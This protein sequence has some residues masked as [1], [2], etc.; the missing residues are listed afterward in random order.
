MQSKE[1]PK[2]QGRSQ[3]VKP[4]CV[5]EPTAYLPSLSTP[6]HLTLYYIFISQFINFGS[7][8]MTLVECIYINNMSRNECSA[9][10]NGFCR[11]SLA[12]ERCQGIRWMD[13]Q[14]C[15]TYTA[16]AEAETCHVHCSCSKIDLTDRGSST[17][18]RLPYPA[19]IQNTHCWPKAQHCG[20]SLWI[21]MDPP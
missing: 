14:H 20:S 1:D 13:Q 2:G 8:T 17:R 18:E 3:K 21:L 6:H 16:A 10:G 11:S 19:V 9:A 15:G 7:T 4:L 5:C 12:W